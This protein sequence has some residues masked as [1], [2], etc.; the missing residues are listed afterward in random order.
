M[1]KIPYNH[2]FFTDSLIV[3]WNSSDKKNKPLILFLNNELKCFCRYR[4]R[5]NDLIAEAKGF[6]LCVGRKYFASKHLSYLAGLLKDMCQS[7][8]S[9]SIVRGCKGPELSE[10]KSTKL[11]LGASMI[12]AGEGRMG[13][14]LGH[15]FVF[16]SECFIAEVSQKVW[17]IWHRML[18]KLVQNDRWFVPTSTLITIVYPCVYIG[19]IVCWRYFSLCFFLTAREYLTTIQKRI[20]SKHAFDSVIRVENKVI[21]RQTT[22]NTFFYY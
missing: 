19:F 17:P 18:L 1:N 2:P 22:K 20:L 16:M 15:E 13:Y 14:L 9:F 7:R 11:A 5:C 21:E 12:E 6:F 3:I 8:W 10:I 4:W